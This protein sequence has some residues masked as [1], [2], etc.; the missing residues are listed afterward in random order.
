MKFSFLDVVEA[1]GFLQTRGLRYRLGRWM[2]RAVISWIYRDLQSR[3]ALTYII[4]TE[5]EIRD[6]K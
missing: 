2:A 4:L 1:K 5:T 6:A 3:R